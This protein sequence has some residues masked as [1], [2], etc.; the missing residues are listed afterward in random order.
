MLLAV[1]LPDMEQSVTRPMKY[2]KIRGG[3]QFSGFTDRTISVSAQLFC[4]KKTVLYNHFMFE[5]TPSKRKDPA[6]SK[7]LDIFLNLAK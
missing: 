5:K 4:S 3:N 1:S 6:F 2:C 7:S